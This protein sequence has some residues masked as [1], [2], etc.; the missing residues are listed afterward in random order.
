MFKQ[1][2]QG[3]CRA[4]LARI[5]ERHASF[6]R[7]SGLNAFWQDI[8]FGI[9]VL[10]KNP[11]FT[12]IAILTLALGIGA[13][14]A[15]FSLLNQVL[16]RRLPV[17]NPDELVM[18][19]SPGPKHGHVWSDGDDSEIF[20]YPLYKGLAKNS[21]VFS[22]VICRYVFSA[23]L[24]TRGQTDRASGELV[25]G[26][27]FDVL[28]V[29]PALGRL[30]SPSDDD[31]QGAHP[32]MVLR[33]GYW[34]QHFASDPGVLNQTVLVNNTEMTIV[35]VAQTGFTGTQVGQTPD[36]FVPITM[37]GQMTP[38]RNGLDD[39][40]DSFLAIFARRKPGI[41]IGQA[42]AGI[43]LEY[44][45]LLE[46]QIDHLA[47]GGDHLPGKERAEFMA[48][49]IILKP[50]AQ[51]RI[52]VQ[53]DSG[54]AIKALF[55]MVAL[56][57]LIAC[58]N[59]AN[60]LLA[61]GSARQ[62]E[63][64]IRTAL[65]ATRGRLVRQL[66]VESFLCALAGGG[67]GLI[68]AAWLM[69]ILT[70][71]IVSES[72]I[73]GITSKLDATVLGFA[74]A[75]TVLSGILFGLLPAWRM[76]RTTV[77]QTM[78]EQGSTTSSAPAH[79]RF[80]KVL[81]AG[82]VAFTLLLLAGAAL[83]TRTLWNL[84]QQN[85]GLTTENLLTFSIQ[86]QLNGYND[87]RTVQLIDQLREHMAALPG[88]RGIG[89][90]EIP[91][92]TGTDMGTNITVEG[93][94]NVESD[95]R[96]IDF[97]AVSPSFF[98]TLGVPL[99]AGREFNAADMATSTK[100]AII[101]EA[102]M[103]AFFPKRDPIGMHFAMG[104]GKGHEPDIQIVG[105]VKNAKQEHV[106]G[107][108]RPYFY[109]PY[110]QAGKLMAMSFYVR[111]QGDPTLIANDLRAVVRKQDANLPVYDLKTMTRV[112]DEDLF[113]E[114][115]IAALSASFGGLAALLAALGIYGV[116]AYLV[117][118][119]TREIGIR[120]ALGAA[121]G[122]VRTLVFKEVGW[123]VFS[124]VAVGLPVAYALARLSE[125]LLFGVR[126]GDVS[127]YLSSLA[128]IAIVA[129]IA[130]YVPSRRATRIDPIVALRYE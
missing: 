14:T 42:S 99:L 77:A 122:H 106:R 66:L 107:D 19:T 59:V 85:L 104:S 61:Q 87:Q 84:R 2:T 124:G 15:I 12:L 105:V 76:S 7:E 67:L 126:A 29:R 48:K 95:D 47:Q 112:V 101:N 53:R 16:L 52:T 100:V 31:V 1:R 128:V 32:V 24:A 38:I 51:G 37:K 39:W 9:R 22:G 54:P 91:V 33:H 21:S 121:S 35:G 60:L 28:G 74:L 6:L 69:N 81:V 115:L 118:Q 46:Q 83:F 130:C 25:S 11:G 108:D 102:M 117:V 41:S 63:F 58:T 75:A 119:R 18:I 123:M 94:E 97:D 27:Y 116:L 49:K 45:G 110:S 78:K 72:G 56:V 79:V 26:N 73:M 68:F 13:N 120:V 90:S 98:S 70:R 10:A 3:L 103:K 17:R 82:Q 36:F 88:V 40:N 93:R 113:A 111:T 34:T 50:G 44:P 43:N 5:V 71:A 20:S 96:H 129:A 125:S 30:L 8:R 65:G 109:L 86:P 80:R 127:A 23:S 4:K 64:S 89:T 55:A 57:L 114:R 92:L 62:R